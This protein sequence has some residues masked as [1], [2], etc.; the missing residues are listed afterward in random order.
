MRSRTSLGV[1]EEGLECEERER[2]E[3]G[4]CRAKQVSEPL[5]LAKSSLRF[6]LGATYPEQ[7]P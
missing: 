7:K 4:I 2:W 6:R 5:P 3:Q 1:G